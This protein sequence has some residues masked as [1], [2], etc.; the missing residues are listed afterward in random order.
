MSNYGRRAFYFA[1]P[2]VWNSL[3]QHIR[4]STSMAVFKRSLT[5]FL[6]HQISHHYT[7][8]LRTPEKGTREMFRVLCMSPR[9][10]WRRWQLSCAATDES[11]CAT[12]VND[13]Y[14]MHA[15]RSRRR[16]FAD[17]NSFHDTS[18]HTG[19][20]TLRRWYTVGQKRKPSLVY[21]QTV[22]NCVPA[23]L[24]GLSYYRP[25]Y[26]ENRT[27]YHILDLRKNLRV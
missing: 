13:A 22:L 6:L 11:N 14:K 12:S 8:R 5:T 19:A 25:P 17:R 27:S 18:D 7:T 15:M 1:G 21:Q 26:A 20:R 4:Q 23:E 3:P 24:R 2:H 9:P 10:Q 16:P